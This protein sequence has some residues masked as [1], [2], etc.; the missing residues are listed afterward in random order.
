MNPYKDATFSMNHYDKDGDLVEDCI[1][2][3][4]GKTILQFSTLTE[5]DGFI[6]RLEVIS[7][8]VKQN[9]CN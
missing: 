6:K 3:H 8:E 2:I 9:Y 5:L 1:M 4:I 7:K